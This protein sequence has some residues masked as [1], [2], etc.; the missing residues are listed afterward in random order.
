MEVNTR[1]TYA[2]INAAGTRSEVSYVLKG[3][4][5]DED[6]AMIMDKCD[7]GE[8]FMPNQVGLH[9]SLQCAIDRVD[10]SPLEKLVDPTMDHSWHRLVEIEPTTATPNCFVIV[11]TRFNIFYSRRVKE[12]SEVVAAFKKITHWTESLALAY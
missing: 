2:Y 12:F 11:P 7:Q 1:L 3:P 5:S 4:P 6:I 10:L 8:F 9:H